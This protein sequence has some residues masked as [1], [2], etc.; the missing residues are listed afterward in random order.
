MCGD[1]DE[2]VNAVGPSGMWQRERGA[3]RDRETLQVVVVV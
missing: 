3:V 1:V 2:D